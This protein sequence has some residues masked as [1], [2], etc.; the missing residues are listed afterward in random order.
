MKNDKP[1]F[2]FRLFRA[3]TPPIMFNFIMKLIDKSQSSLFDGEQNALLFKK[4]IQD[5]RVYGE[6]GCGLSTNYVLKNT[7]CFVIA[8]DSSSEWVELVEKRANFSKKLDINYIDVGVV[9][10]W[11]RPIDYKKRENFKDYTDQLWGR[12]LKPDLVLIDGRFRVACFLTCLLK[13]PIGTVIIFDDYINRPQYHIVESFACLTE[14]SGRQAVFI[15][16][17]LTQDQVVGVQNMLDKF[18]YV[19]D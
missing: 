15:K 2:I 11:G 6:Y 19:M 12:N 3:F 18:R 7:N 9:G 17:A 5:C 1:A 10:D 4:Y 14:F 16:Q 8:T 13:A